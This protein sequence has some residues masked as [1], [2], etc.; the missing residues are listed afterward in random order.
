MIKDSLPDIQNTVPFVQVNIDK[1]G[2]NSLKLPLMFKQKDNV[3]QQ[4]E[5]DISCYVD[6]KKNI[7]GIS[8]S[9]ILE[10]LHENSGRPFNMEIMQNISETIKNRTESKSCDLTFNFNYFVKKISPVTNKTGFIHYNV[11]LNT[12]NKRSQFI[13]TYQIK[14]YVTS[15]CPCSKEIS[16]N[17]AHNQ[18]CLITIKYKTNDWIWI[19][20]VI[21]SIE[22]CGS[23]EIYSILKRP[24]EKYVTEFAYDNPLFVED[25]ARNCYSVLQRFSSINSFSIK[26]ES[27]ESIHI[28]KAVA[29]INKNFK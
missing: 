29:I 12:L 24:D 7:K 3:F 10:V 26:V 8:M 11:S 19:E 16:N 25:I 27:D 21:D 18:K 5:T 9:R 20:D 28:H 14:L 15:L 22:K 6:L 2:I 13:N 23:C 1:V 17:S 4:V